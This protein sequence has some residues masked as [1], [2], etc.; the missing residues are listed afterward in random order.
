MDS[1]PEPYLSNARIC[2]ELA[3]KVADRDAKQLLLNTAQQW[4]ALAA[5]AEMTARKTPP[6]GG[7]Q[8]STV[9]VSKEPAPPPSRPRRADVSR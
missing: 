8:N 5:V 7:A 3:T 4:R 2:E 6:W 1:D 9:S